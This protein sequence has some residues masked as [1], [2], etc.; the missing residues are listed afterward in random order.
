MSGDVIG[1]IMLTIAAKFSKPK[2]ST[3][4]SAQQTQQRCSLFSKPYNLAFLLGLWA[5]L[6]MGMTRQSLQLAIASQVLMGTVYV[7]FYQWVNEMNM[8]YAFGDTDTYSRI[9]TVCLLFFTSF[10]AVA[11]SSALLL[12]DNF[13]RLAPFYVSAGFCCFAIVVYV[14]CFLPRVKCGENLEEIEEKRYKGS[15]A[16]VSSEESLN[17]VLPH[18][19]NTIQV[20]PA[21]TDESV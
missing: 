20:R 12:Y 17:G 9:R 11:S 14:M 19:V 1:A 15:L 16:G 13:S 4:Q 10:N 21:R 8:F 7:F 5:F 3:D 18:K 2:S 6:N